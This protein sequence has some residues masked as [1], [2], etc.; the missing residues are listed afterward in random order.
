MY[1]SKMALE[2]N[3]RP[4]LPAALKRRVLLECGH[5]CSIHTCR[6]PEVD[7]H[8]IV[9]WSIC[10]E[11]RFE[12][13]IAVCPNCHRRADRNEIDLKSLYVYKERLRLGLGI[14]T[15]P[16]GF[17]TCESTT[18]IEDQLFDY[19]VQLIVPRIAP[20]N[21]EINQ[22]NAVILA[23]FLQELHEMRSQEA[24]A[25]SLEKREHKMVLNYDY[26]VSFLNDDLASIFIRRFH[27][28]S[29]AGAAHPNHDSYT[30]NFNLSP[31]YP[32][33]LANIFDERTKYLDF[34]STFAFQDLSAQLS[35]PEEALDDM[36]EAE[37]NNHNCAVNERI[38][39][40]TTPES[41]NFRNFR[42]T[43]SSLIFIFDEFQVA[44]YVAG[45]RE[46][47]IPY[48]AMQEFISPKSAVHKAY[49]KAIHG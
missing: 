25:I 44:E 31:S 9:P 15:L 32:L 8:H 23:R 47:E 43:K 11:H 29:M 3:G 16:E 45:A 20:A 46:V 6:H 18:I 21:E 14:E 30:F 38:R 41:T 40:G 33:T 36:T 13:L 49:D 42:L 17:L 28:A 1:H 48:G 7:I 12:N 34:L 10:K 39:E 22:V 2:K 24:A 4:A 5:R 37:F 19:D 27:D 26:D 35:L